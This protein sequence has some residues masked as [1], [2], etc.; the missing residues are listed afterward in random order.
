[1]TAK[2]KAKDLVD[3]FLQ[4]GYTD[5]DAVECALICV[6]E[7]LRMDLKLFDITEF[8]EVKRELIRK[9]NK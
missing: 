5:D 4:R 2:E 1:M 9:M 3:K 6:G 8:S 7:I